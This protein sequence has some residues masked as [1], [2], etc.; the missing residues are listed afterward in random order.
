MVYNC[1]W[2]DYDKYGLILGG[3][4]IINKGCY[5][6]FVLLINGVIVV[7]GDVSGFYRVNLG[8]IFDV[9]DM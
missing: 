4:Y 5:L 3:G 1:L 7:M 9:W 6:V 8:D 2:F